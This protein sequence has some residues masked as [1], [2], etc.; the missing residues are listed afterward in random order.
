MLWA[1][2]YRVDA[3]AAPT[4]EAVLAAC[5]RHIR[6]DRC[7]ERIREASHASLA[8]HG[9]HWTLVLASLTAQATIGGGP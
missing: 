5:L 2:A 1:A 9:E 4:G 3:Q 6:N 8:R 7:A